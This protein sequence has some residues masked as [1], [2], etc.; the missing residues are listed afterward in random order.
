MLALKDFKPSKV[1]TR[2]LDPRAPWRHTLSECPLAL[3]YCDVRLRG[4]GASSAGEEGWHPPSPPLSLVGT[5]LPLQ[6]VC[7][8]GTGHVVTSQACDTRK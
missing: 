4:A 7:K 1:T 3:P 2:M 8:G 5:P 6:S